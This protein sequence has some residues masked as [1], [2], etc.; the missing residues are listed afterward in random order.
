MRAF[1]IAALPW[2]LSG[3]AIAIICANLKSMEVKN[4]SE[5][6]SYEKLDVQIAIGMLFGLVLGVMLNACGLWSNQAIGFAVGP[7]WGMA[8]AMLFPGKREENHE[9]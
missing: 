5:N 6:G 9:E 4:K 2:V 1:L 7:L 8:I 3:I